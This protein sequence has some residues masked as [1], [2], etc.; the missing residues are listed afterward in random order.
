MLI[1]YARV[2]TEDQDP[3]LQISALKEFGCERI[4]TDHA[5]GKSLKR[6]EWKKCRMD[7]RKGDTLVIWKVDRLARSLHDL[8]SV[9]L[10]LEEEGIDLVILTQK[11]DT[12]SAMGKA[13]FH[14]MGVMAELE[15]SLISDRTKAGM[16]ESASRGT[17]M[18]GKFKITPALWKRLQELIAQHR[19]EKGKDPSA[20]WLEQK[21]GKKV[22]QATIKNHRDVIFAGG[23]YPQ[24]W[25]ERN[26]QAERRSKAKK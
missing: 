23:E 13:M 19:D 16:S 3:A 17:I 15:R 4:Y 8:I 21:I 12:R 10:S 6:P 11:V 20:Y 1:G 9:S 5:S 22:T 24:A 14:M 2:S 7:L 25:R 26:E 18:G